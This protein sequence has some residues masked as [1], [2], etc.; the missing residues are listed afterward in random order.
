MYLEGGVGARNDSAIAA[1]RERLHNVTR[2]ALDAR[3]DT[4]L[5]AQLRDRLAGLNLTVV[6][7]A[8]VIIRFYGTVTHLRFGRKMRAGEA[9]ILK[10]GRPIFRYQMKAEQYRV[11]DNPAEAFARVLSDV[12]R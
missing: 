5:V 9:T 2:V 10:N 1:A 4:D 6:D 12:F 11:G 8:D 3:G 7:R